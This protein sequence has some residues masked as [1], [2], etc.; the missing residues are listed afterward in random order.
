MIYKCDIFLKMSEKS[1]KA[2]FI[3]VAIIAVAIAVFAGLWQ[4]SGNKK[5]KEKP[6]PVFERGFIHPTGTPFVK[7]PTGPPPV[8]PA[9]D[10]VPLR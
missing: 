6:Q 3:I 10:T 7:G 2:L 1:K 9:P 5:N 8:P 4:A